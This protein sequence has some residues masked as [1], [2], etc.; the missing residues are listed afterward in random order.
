MAAV[1]TMFYEAKPLMLDVIRTERARFFDLAEDPANW[2][3]QTRCT[4]WE[5]RDIVGHMIDVTEAYL[6]RF[7]IGRQG[8]TA[9]N[10]GLLAMADRAN[11]R[12]KTFRSLEQG[13]AIARLRK[14]SDEL[15][16]L[17]EALTED[18]WS[19]LLVP[20]A[21][22]GPIPSFIYTAF[23]IMDYGVHT[24]DIRWGLGDKLGLLDERTAGVLVPYMFV[25][26]QSTVDAA[27]A[28]GL[29]TVYG[30]QVD[31]EW[32]GRWRV[33]VKDGT[34]SHAPEEGSWEGCQA[35]F[36]FNSS[37]DFVL[38]SFIRF[39]GGSASGD[40]EVIERVRGLFFSI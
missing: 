26:M 18:E 33:T 16:A 30:I 28:A 12:A 9:P 7:P 19:G 4:E 36:H 38:T 17:F 23:Q 11:E 25:L 32:G 13:E 35:L 27:S 22:M 2:H 15:M 37:S 31:G 24:W 39:H 10:Y 40:H 29:D 1:N 14:A 8:G 21:Y 5:T 3:V 20:H 34:W 6:E